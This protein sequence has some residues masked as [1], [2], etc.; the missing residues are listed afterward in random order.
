M[1]AL[2]CSDGPEPSSVVCATKL[3]ENAPASAKVRIAKLD[4]NLFF[5]RYLL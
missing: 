1:G 5:I 3:V 2:G 4:R